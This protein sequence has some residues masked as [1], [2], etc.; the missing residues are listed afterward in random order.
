MRL[1]GGESTKGNFLSASKVFKQ[2]S[3]AVFLGFFSGFALAQKKIEKGRKKAA[4][5]DALYSAIRE[6]NALQSHPFAQLMNIL[7]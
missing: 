5:T 3:H 2:L 4:I 6:H 7:I 1:R